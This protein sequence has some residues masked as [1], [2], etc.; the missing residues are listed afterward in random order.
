LGVAALAHGLY[1]AFIVIPA[2]AD[3]ALFGSLIFILAVFQFFRELRARRPVRG[4]PVSLTATFLFGVSTV[5][6]A[7]FVYTSAIV[8]WEA[9][10]DT[11]VLG[12]AGQ[13]IMVYLF[14]R[15]MPET[16]VSV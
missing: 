8:G 11:L 14:L 3:Y 15:E 1:D 4:E 7:T 13:A 9:A 12:A 2:L 16:M 6:A 10:A 5:A